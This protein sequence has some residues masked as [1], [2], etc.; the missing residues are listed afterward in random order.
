LSLKIIFFIPIL[1][2]TVFSI[3][4]KEPFDDYLCFLKA[5][6]LCENMQIFEFSLKYMGE[7]VGAGAENFDKPEPHKNGPALQ[8]W[9]N[10]STQL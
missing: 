7:M 5:W 1:V 10:S 6:K 3:Y 9:F 4:F 8:H 2:G